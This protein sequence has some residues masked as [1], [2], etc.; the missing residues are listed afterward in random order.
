M[1]QALSSE[2]EEHI[3]VCYI[4]HYNGRESGLM[5]FSNEAEDPKVVFAGCNEEAE[6]GAEEIIYPPE[7]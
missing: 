7:V 3:Y 5:S 6:E 1:L 2:H 4:N